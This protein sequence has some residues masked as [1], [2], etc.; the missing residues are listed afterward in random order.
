MTLVDL[1]LLA[2]IAAMG[3]VAFF[4]LRKRRKQGRCCG[5]GCAGCAQAGHCHSDKESTR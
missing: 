4:A 5:G 1:V 3:V 2:V